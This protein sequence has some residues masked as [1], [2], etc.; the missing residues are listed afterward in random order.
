MAFDLYDPIQRFRKPITP[1]AATDPLDDMRAGTKVPV[2]IAGTK[3][4]VPEYEDRIAYVGDNQPVP[5]IL[6]ER[7][8]APNLPAVE[9]KPVDAAGSYSLP[10]PYGRPRPVD[11]ITG[12]V[13]RA[14]NVYNPPVDTPQVAPPRIA[15]GNIAPGGMMAG[16]GVK[17]PRTVFDTAGGPPPVSARTEVKHPKGFWGKLGQTLGRIGEGA[18]LGSQFG[19][20]GAIYGAVKGGVDPYAIAKWKDK[21]IIMPAYEA[22]RDKEIKEYQQQQ[23][24]KN[25]EED[26]LR[27][28]EMMRINQENHAIAVKDRE[29]NISRQEKEDAE[30]RGKIEYERAQSTGTAVNPAAVKGTS[31]AAYAGQIPPRRD[32]QKPES[33]VI[34]GNLIRINPEGG[35]DTLYTAP[36]KPISPAEAARDKKEQRIEAEQNRK[37]DAGIAAQFE[38]TKKEL[39][40]ASAY[41]GALVNAKAAGKGLKGELLPPSDEDIKAAQ[42]KVD[43][44]KSE[45]SA[46]QEQIRS[47]PRLKLDKSQTGIDYKASRPGQQTSLGPASA[48]FD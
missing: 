43:G 22:R 41:Y 27:A 34:N 21:N 16:E 11:P 15:P 39:N 19:V 3:R 7:I 23:A 31:W 1:L 33:H 26:N 17:D 18:L 24:M 48:Y 32:A 44:L 4:P 37:E 2:P 30:Q 40:E 35:V 47:H 20:G 46:L 6:T 12:E 45:F 29:R 25:V 5:P 10:M 13:N 42:G 9:A 36:P 8:A 28:A 38:K 14:A